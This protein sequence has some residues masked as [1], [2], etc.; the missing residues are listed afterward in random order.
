[1]FSSCLFEHI[2]KSTFPDNQGTG[3]QDRFL[4]IHYYTQ[5]F[6]GLGGSNMS[7]KIFVIVKEYTCIHCNRMLIFLYCQACL[8]MSFA[9][10][11]SRRI[12][13]IGSL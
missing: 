4:L 11:V 2:E 1:M 3:Q 13:D 5:V 12:L 9:L 7:Y 10:I 8:G 6:G